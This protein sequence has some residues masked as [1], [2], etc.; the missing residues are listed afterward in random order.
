MI[1]F[2]L[3]SFLSFNSFSSGML[4][5]AMIIPYLNYCNLVLGSAQ[6]YKTN[7]QRIVILQKRVIRTVNKSYSNAYTEPNFKKF[8][9]LK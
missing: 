1:E 9:F 7:L 8:N 5:N 6:A 3:G 4:Y 2:Q